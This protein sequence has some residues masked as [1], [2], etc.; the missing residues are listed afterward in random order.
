MQLADEKTQL[1]YLGDGAQRLMF[2]SLNLHCFGTDS[3][4]TT[5]W[6]KV[7]EPLKLSR[8]DGVA[9]RL[10]QLSKAG[11]PG[12]SLVE[13]FEYLRE[14]KQQLVLLLDEF[15]QLLY[16]PHF[17]EFS[18]YATLRAVAGCR[19]LSLI[20]ASRFALDKL[21]EQVHKL[22]ASGGSPVLNY[23]TE[24]RLL[25][26]DEKGVNALL[27]RAG[28]A[29]SSDDHLFIRFMAGRHPYLVQAMSAALLETT[30]GARYA[31]AT[32]LYYS[33]VSSHFDDLWRMLDDRTRTTI[34]VLGLV[35]VGFCK[36][37]AGFNYRESS[38]F[39][40][41]YLLWQDERWTLGSQ[42]FLCWVYDV[43][44]VGTRMV[45]AY[46]EWLENEGYR[47]LLKREQW[48]QLLDTVRRA[49]GRKICDIGTM[50]EDMFKELTRRGQ[51]DPVR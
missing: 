50:A 22:P 37:G 51:N 45:S 10:E 42:A 7:L 43:A 14:H 17:Q 41:R 28:D 3:S 23:P 15:D 6:G 35:E 44:T 29:L 11:Y 46:E 1:R 40:T 27:N 9:L 36:L 19:S 33:R 38:L 4:P 18:F 8:Q 31:C 26:F 49:V 39:N 16:L 25:P 20:L 21:Q 24:V 30:N 2:L 5:F 47:S 48:E 12:A 32:E 13:L 34:V